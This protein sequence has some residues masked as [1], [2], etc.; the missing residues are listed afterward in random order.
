M[1]NKKEKKVLERWH[2]A[3]H[4]S[5]RIHIFFLFFLFFSALLL[6]W[7]YFELNDLS[8][9]IV[10]KEASMTPIPSQTETACPMLARLC[11]DGVNYVGMHGPKCEF[12][13]CPGQ[14]CGGNIANAPTCSTGYH[15]QVNIQ[16]PD[17]GGTCIAN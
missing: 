11:P 12:D 3:H 13:A 14:H 10:K 15:C 2:G 5:N 8:V 1:E 16:L 9:K 6:L 4:Y 7:S 17:V